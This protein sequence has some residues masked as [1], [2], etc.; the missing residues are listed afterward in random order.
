MTVVNDVIDIMCE[1][2]RL[3]RNARSIADILVHVDTSPASRVRLWLAAQ[4]A[5]RFNAY[6]VAVGSEEAALAEDRF[7]KMLSEE[8]LRGEWQTATGLVSSYV[9]RQACSADLVILGQRDRSRVGALDAPE[10]VILACGRPVLVIP[11][12]NAFDRVGETVLVAWNNSPQATRAVHDALPLMATSKAVTVLSVNPEAADE[13]EQCEALVRHL[14]RHGLRAEAQVRHSDAL[15]VAD[16]ALS[17][18]AEL[19]CDLLVMGAYGHS[20]L[21]EMVLGG[22]T[23]DMLRRMTLPVLMS[24]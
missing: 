2:M 13:G 1:R 17:Q 20:R 22:M 24:H 16:F 18:A 15:S 5:R 8:N 10:D 11:N 14:A 9:T 7:M 23:R 3:W 4:L 6:L 12:A 21:R 19:G